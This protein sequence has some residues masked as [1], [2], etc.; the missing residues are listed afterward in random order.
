[1]QLIAAVGFQLIA[2]TIG[3]LLAL[4]LFGLPQAASLLIGGACATI[5]WALVAIRENLR[6]RRDTGTLL[7]DFVLGHLGKFA[8]TCALLVLAHRYLEPLHWPAVIVG[9]MI[10]VHMPMFALLVPGNTSLRP[11]RRSRASPLIDGDPR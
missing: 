8:L 4:V 9:L 1:M 2:L 10:A 11:S 5:P 6:G 7:L 3:A